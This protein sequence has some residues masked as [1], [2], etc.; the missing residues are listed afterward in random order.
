[1]IPLARIRGKIPICGNGGST[2]DALM[3]PIEGDLPARGTIKR[4]GG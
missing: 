1:M 4:T 3:E 2:G